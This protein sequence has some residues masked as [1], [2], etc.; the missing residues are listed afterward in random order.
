MNSNTIINGHDD[1]AA[2]GHAAADHGPSQTRRAPGADPIRVCFY[3][4]FPGAGSGT[5]R[6]GHEVLT[7]LAALPGVEP[8]LVCSPSCHW[9]Q[10]AS[11]EC[12]PILRE[13]AHNVPWRRR[14]RFLIAQFTNPH[15]MLRFARQSGT[16]IL[17][18]GG[19]NQLTFPFWEPALRRYQGVKV[20]TVHDVLR[21]EGMKW[22]SPR[23]ENA[24]LSKIYRS[25]DA[26]FVHGTEQ[27]DQLESVGV[28]PERIVV[29]PHG[30]YDCGA[31]S[32]SIGELRQK[33]QLRRDQP[34]ALAF[35]NVRDDKNLTL[36]IRAVARVQRPVQ[37]LVAG[38][39]ATLQQTTPEGCLQLARE[40]G[41]G[42]RIRIMNCFITDE[43]IPEL[44][45]LSD[46]VALPYSRTFTSQSGVLAVAMQYDRPVLVSRTGTAV[47]TLKT[48]RIGVG[49][50][51]DELE[52]LTSGI[53][54]IQ[55]RID[56]GTKFEFDRYRQMY[57]W[58]ENAHVT[59]ETY[60]RL[61][62]AKPAGGRR[63]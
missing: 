23:Y 22:K 53:E 55:Q 31:T 60:R 45:R 39:F 57:S 40:L 26:L 21:R 15:R 35:G 17:H 2:N 44:F 1:V 63:K 8:T 42:E 14:L 58:P 28:K 36:L 6:Y 51:P 16:D 32:K 50:E 10:F 19:V 54:E 7:H 5:G 27:V 33:Y 46:W 11:Y 41:I 62:A 61:L 49:V 37:L 25:L 12:R 13:L 4:F 20:A 24:Q 47:D 3:M 52:S 30:P 56:D 29:V 34:V 18:F 38:K 48:C 9:Q 59:V 43:Q